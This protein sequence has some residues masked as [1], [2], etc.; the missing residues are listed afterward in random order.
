MT[1]FTDAPAVFF[2]AAS[3]ALGG[4]SVAGA[5][6]GAAVR[7]TGSLRVASLRPRP[8]CVAASRRAS[9]PGSGLGGGSAGV[10]TRM[11][12]GAVGAAL[13]A[14]RTPRPFCVPERMRSTLEGSGFSATRCTPD[15]GRPSALLAA[16]FASG[17]N[18]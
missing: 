3:A 8:R 14:M 1:T 13:V 4:A 16:F 17:P 11:G 7:T 5:S 15:S 9:G 12:G 18:P 2:S 6:S 10:S